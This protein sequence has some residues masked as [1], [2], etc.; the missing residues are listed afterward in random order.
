MNKEEKELYAPV[1][2]VRRRT[3]LDP[4][5]YHYKLMPVL[6]QKGFDLIFNNLKLYENDKK[7]NEIS[8]EIFQYKDEKSNIFVQE[9]VLESLI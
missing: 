7:E 5:V 4:L 6:V 2:K 9:D 3:K 1:L 8:L